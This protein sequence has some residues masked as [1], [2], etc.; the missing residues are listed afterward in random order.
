MQEISCKDKELQAIIKNFTISLIILLLCRPCTLQAQLITGIVLDSLTHAPIPN[1]S[2]SLKT[3]SGGTLTGSDGSFRIRVARE[4]AEFIFTA[5]GYT[6]LNLDLRDSTSHHVTVFLS[7]SYTEL[8]GFVVARKKKYRN[9]HN[10]AVE[11]IRLVIAGKSRNGPEGQS[12]LSFRQYEKTRLMVDEPPQLLTDNRLL[13]KYRFLFDNKDTLTMPGKLLIPIYMEE[14]ISQNYY[15]QHPEKRKKM[16]IGRKNVDYGEYIDMRGISEALNRLYE[17][18]RI[19]DNSI[20]VFTM[21]FTSPIADLSPTFYMYFIRD[22]IVENGVKLVRLDFTPRNPEDLL[23]RGTLYIT[24]DGNYAVRKAELEVPPRINLN[25]VRDFK[26]TQDFQQGPGGHYQ[27]ASSDVAAFFS[28]LPR[29]RGLYGERTLSI[30]QVSDST[31][32]DTLLQGPRTDTLVQAQLQ[33]TNFW[34]EGRTVP[35]SESESKVYSNTDSLVHMRSYKRLMDYITLF[36]AGF[37]SAGPFDIGPVSSFYTFNP[38]EGK[39]LRFGGRSNTKLSDRFY[40][41]DYIAYGL[42]DQRWKYY[43]S[44]TYS[45][46]HQSIYQ[47]PFNYIQ[48]SYLHD[49]RNPGQE[50]AFSQGSSFL[51]SFARGD[52]TRWLYNDIA[53]LSYVHEFGNHLSYTFGMKYWQQHPAGS[54]TYIYQPGPNTADTIQTITTSELSVSLRWAPYEQFFQSKNGRSDIINKYPIMTLQYTRGVKGMFQGQYNYNAVH[55]R[56]YKRC[57]LSPLGFSDVTFDAGYLSGNLPFPLLIIPP[58]NQT[59]YYTQNAYNLMNYGEFVSDHFAGV[60]IDHFFN[61]FFFNK[62]PLL[63]KLRLREVIAAKVLYGGVRDENNPALNPAQMK[64]PLTNGVNTTYVLGNQ[65]YVEASVGIYNIFSI[66]R[67]DL[68]KRFTYLNHYDVSGLGLRISSNFS[69]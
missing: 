25:W 49:T 36:A 15:R 8:S 52:N 51:S 22:T 27:L 58:A 35:L 48:A 19:Y 1:V 23:F 44:V 47:Y 61:G 42:K 2:L 69:F 56:I 60:N 6:S 3:V 30:S 65:P 18:I 55:L 43:T 9:R 39:R 59:Y 33:P 45:F 4:H 7:K 37:K 28:P 67:L 26:V 12:Y 16:V 5:M 64:F 50:N 53:R 13:K 21:Q 24:L 17:D 20:P 29:S 54:L 57:Y 11:L 62:V 41:S 46:N 66:F 31:L 34:V 14:V 10:P 68:V 32:A 40:T 38:I 63:K